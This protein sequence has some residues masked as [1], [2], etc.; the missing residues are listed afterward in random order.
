VQGYSSLVRPLNALLRKGVA[1]QW[2]AQCQD[3]FEG[4]KRALIIAPVLAMPE[5][6]DDAP[7]FFVWCDASDFALRAVLLQGGKV[8]ANEAETLNSAEQ[9]YST[10]EKELLGVVHALGVWRC[11]LE[12]GKG[13]R[14]MIDH[15]P[16]T[17]LPSQPI[18]SR[19]QARWSGFLQRFNTLTWHYKPGRINVADPVSGSPLL[20]NAN[21]TDLAAEEWKSSGTSKHG[22]GCQ[23]N[24]VCPGW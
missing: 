7:D 18:L 12:G 8:I 10:G 20:D 3:A 14:V 9:N 21:V 11:Y 4:L 1:Y 23:C 6:S 17:Y 5:I 24:S 16:N 15:A 2:T 22:G 19:R 13:V